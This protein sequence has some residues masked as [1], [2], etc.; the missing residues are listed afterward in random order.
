M[1]LGIYLNTSIIPANHTCIQSSRKSE[2][3]GR[4][5]RRRRKHSARLK[6]SDIEVRRPTNRARLHQET[7]MMVPTTP[8]CVPTQSKHH[9]TNPFLPSVTSLPPLARHLLSSMGRRVLACQRE[10]SMVLPTATTVPIVTV[11]AT[12]SRH[13]ARPRQCISKVISYS[14]ES[15]IT[16]C[17]DVSAIAPSSAN[18]QR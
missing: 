11:A 7:P 5:R 18:F 4:Q 3:N 15:P 6:K 1:P 17:A 8:T 16:T 14:T 10:F 9:L 12:P 2:K 13:T